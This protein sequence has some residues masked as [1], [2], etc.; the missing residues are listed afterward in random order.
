MKS[1]IILPTVVCVCI[2]YPATVVLNLLL[3][4]LFIVAAPYMAC[5]AFLQVYVGQ[6]G[7]ML[8]CDLCK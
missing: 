8:Q 2:C 1:D 5:S 3:D 7:N 6:K 4:Y